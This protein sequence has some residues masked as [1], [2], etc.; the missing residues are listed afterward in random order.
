MSID[1]A[2]TEDWFSAAYAA[3]LADANAKAALTP[4]DIEG[5]NRALD[6]PF[7]ELPFVTRA[8]VFLLF[9]MGK[10]NVT[11]AGDKLTHPSWKPLA[12]YQVEAIEPPKT[13]PSIDWSH[14]APDYRWLARDSGEDAYVYAA[15]PSC[16]THGWTAQG[17][18]V[19]AAGL[20]SY[21]PGDCD[22]QDSL[23]ERPA[24]V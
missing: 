14:L 1:N 20:A 8:Y 6:R 15:K 5:L 16:G 3:S 13:K 10:V 19:L 4:R 23:V 18:A 2:S 24:G 11:L 22:W 12:T 7:G 9:Q 17:L 21:A